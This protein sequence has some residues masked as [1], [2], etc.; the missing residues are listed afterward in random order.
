VPAAR[1]DAPPARKRKAEQPAAPAAAQKQSKPKPPPAAAAPQQPRGAP[2][3]A[4]RKPKPSG[5]RPDYGALAP[6]EQ[7]RRAPPAAYTR[8]RRTHAHAPDG[9]VP[10]FAP[11][12]SL[13][14]RAR[15]CFPPRA[16]SA[17]WASY[18]SQCGGSF[19]EEEAFAAAH[20]A[21]LPPGPS[22]QGR[23]KAGTP[24]WRDTLA[25]AP[26][27]APPGAPSVLVITGAA[28]VRAARVPTRA[29]A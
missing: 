1:D 7:A 29:H 27:G 18:Q 25:R 15:C 11:P 13:T 9:C 10:S 6:E 3:A 17:L 24:T 4:A 19:L 23:L 5:E 12:A 28:E 26:N 8:A 16:R 2:P 22:L 14:R 21:A 20:F